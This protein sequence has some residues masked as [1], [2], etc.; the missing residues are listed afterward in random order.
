MAQL[1][2]KDHGPAWSHHISGSAQVLKIRSPESLQS[3][4]AMAL[5]AAHVGAA[6]SEAFMLNKHCECAN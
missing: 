3:E 1:L 6:I 4:F 2:D 5:F